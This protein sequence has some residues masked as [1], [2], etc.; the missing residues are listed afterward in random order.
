MKT[1][2]D[3]L[4]YSCEQYN[5]YS[6]IG[7]DVFKFWIVLLVFVG[8]QMAWNLRSF[9]GDKNESFKL[10]RE[11]EGNFYTA[12]IYSVNQLNEGDENQNEREY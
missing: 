10:F 3:A 9:L 4:R 1:I 7:V 11:C 2:I 8:I 6:K 12:L 5:I